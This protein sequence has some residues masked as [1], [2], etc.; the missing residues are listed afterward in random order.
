MWQVVIHHP[1]AFPTETYT[2]DKSIQHFKTEQ[3]MDAFLL[4]YTKSGPALIQVVEVDD[5]FDWYIG[6][7]GQRVIR[8]GGAR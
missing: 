8:I 3:E 2:H 1:V 4:E 6:D 5:E 7:D